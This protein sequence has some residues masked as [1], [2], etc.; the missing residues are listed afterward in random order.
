MSKAQILE[1]GSK[2]R[3]RCTWCGTVSESTIPESRMSQRKKEC[4]LMRCYS[5]KKVSA[6]VAE[7]P[8][9][10]ETSP[11]D[12]PDTVAPLGGRVGKCISGRVHTLGQR[13]PRAAVTR[14]QDLTPDKGSAATSLTPVGQRKRHLSSVPPPEK[15]LKPTCELAYMRSDEEPRWRPGDEVEVAWKGRG[16]EASLFFI[17]KSHTLSPPICHR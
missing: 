17:F 15:T 13:S 1:P 5:C 7:T 8:P 14:R 3:M 12:P 4:Y 16:Y 11:D 9:V 6:P 10:A 2:V